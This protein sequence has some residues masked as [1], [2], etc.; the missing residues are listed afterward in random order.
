[1]GRCHVSEA[2]LVMEGKRLV[3]ISECL[4]ADGVVDASG[5]LPDPLWHRRNDRLALLWPGDWVE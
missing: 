2:D 1:M 5:G 3:Q 4:S